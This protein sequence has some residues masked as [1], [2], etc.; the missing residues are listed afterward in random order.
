MKFWELMS[1]INPDVK[2]V[3]TVASTKKEWQF[4]LDWLSRYDTLVDIQD[5]AKLDYELPDQFAQEVL[6][7]CGRLYYLSKDEIWL[8]SRLTSPDD[9]ILTALETFNRYGGKSMDDVIEYGSFK[10]G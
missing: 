5:R 1:V 6:K 3:N 4:I 2:I 9:R 7:L 8:R 10:V